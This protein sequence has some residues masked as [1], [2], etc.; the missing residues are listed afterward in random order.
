M[1]KKIYA[2]HY[3]GPEPECLIGYYSSLEKVKLYAELDAHSSPSGRN[4]FEY[5][6]VELPLNKYPGSLEA[7]TTKTYKY[8]VRVGKDD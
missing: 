2:L 3:D 7:W 5:K 6:I 1:S 8:F 4:L